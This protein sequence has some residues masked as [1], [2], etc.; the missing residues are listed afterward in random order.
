M[1]NQF[2]QYGNVTPEG[3]RVIQYM[4]AAAQVAEGQDIEALNALSGPVKHYYVNVTKLH[5]M[6]PAR[7]LEDY[8]NAAQAIMRNLTEAETAQAAAD[9]DKQ[10]R[11]ALAESLEEVKAA[12]ALA[13][14]KIAQLEAEGEAADAAAEMAGEES[15]PPAD[16]PAPDTRRGKRS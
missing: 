8:T 9:A 3:Q 6:T 16:E 1:P 14:A 10:E 7:W 5:L 4:E 2:S 12:L 15:A 13:M 11:A